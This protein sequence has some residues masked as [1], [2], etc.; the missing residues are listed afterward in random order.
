VKLLLIDEVHLLDED[1]GSVIESIVAR[2]LCGEG[3][4]EDF[5]S[6]NEIGWI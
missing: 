4:F 1:R 6:A 3:D 5:A 2:T